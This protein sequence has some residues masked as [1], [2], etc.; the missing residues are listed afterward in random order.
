MEPAGLTGEGSFVRP[1]PGHRSISHDMRYFT[2]R[3]FRPRQPATGL[4]GMFLFALVAAGS[5]CAAAA[6]DESGRGRAS[7]PAAIRTDRSLFTIPFRLPEPRRPDEAPQRV[8]LSVSKD[9]GNT[10]QQIDEVSPQAGRFTYRAEAD[11]E[12]W[13]RL[14]AID[15]KGRKRGG[16][17][18]DIRVVVD[19]G[20]PRLAARVWRGADGEIICRYAAVDDS[21]AVDRLKI[22]YRTTAEPEWR[23][24]ASEGILSR[25]SPAH[26]I[27]EEIWWAGDETDG[28]TVRIA[29]SDAG[30][31]E[32]VRQFALEPTDPGIDQAALA[33]EIGAPPLPRTA[34]P[35]SIATASPSRPAGVPSWLS[36]GSEGGWA[37]ERAAAP[38]TR[39]RA[40]SPTRSVLS[41][42]GLSGPRPTPA[43]PEAS[44]TNEPPGGAPRLPGL[45]LEREP[46]G[47]ARPPRAG[48]SLPAGT[49]STA[50]AV[51]AA[52][53]YRG[54]PLMLSSSTRFNWDYEVDLPR[55]NREPLRVELW[56]TR[57][58]GVTWQRAAVDDDVSSPIE[59]SLESEG[60]YG[61]MLL[62]VPDRGGLGSGPRTGEQPQ[63]WV[64]VDTTPPQVANLEVEPAEDSGEESVTIHYTASDPLLSP[65][66]VR[67]LFSPSTDGP[68]ATVAEGL[69]ASGSHR[70]TPGRGVPPRVFLRVE[71]SDAAGNT[72]HTTT[73]HAVLVCPARQSGRLGTIRPLPSEQP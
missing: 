22:E 65:G 25:E 59:V 33:R 51:A 62:V 37:P 36:G 6:A 70:W 57:D 42:A 21:L 61:F 60:L 44:P 16:A 7:L 15:A 11:G 24:V 26:M 12:Y 58:A 4:P 50:A 32:T 53:E 17:G 34:A 40:S 72:G 52:S 28:L 1:A 5:C 43:P 18:P 23:S 2:V 30:G 46:G 68:W 73:P 3:G 54:K 66:S 64:G 10:W 39:T 69:E 31:S 45:P 49:G 35:A 14:R 8:V 63:A 29:I 9:L 47:D 55:Y 48:G 19:A 56:S 41:R 67:I 38:P 13:F 71:A 20:G 27:G